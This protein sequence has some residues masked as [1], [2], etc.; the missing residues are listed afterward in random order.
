MSKRTLPE[1]QHDG[2]HQ[3]DTACPPNLKRQRLQP[4]SGAPVADA[5]YAPYRK[6]KLPNSF[7]VVLPGGPNDIKSVRLSNLQGAIPSSYQ[8]SSSCPPLPDE[9]PSASLDGDHQFTA[10]A[11][12]PMESSEALVLRPSSTLLPSLDQ[13]LAPPFHQLPPADPL[14]LSIVPYRQHFDWWLDSL[15]ASEAEKEWLLANRHLVTKLLEEMLTSSRSAGI[16]EFPYTDIVAL[17]NIW[18]ERRE[19]AEVKR[20]E[21]E[22]SNGEGRIF[23]VVDEEEG[24]C[25]E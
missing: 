25:L 18:R 2:H 24:M 3:Q 1:D 11:F 19:E 9:A 22:A 5:S 15:R 20:R 10:D 23:E 16:P 14:S 12:G 7:D 4:T 6:R 21:E 17:R 8:Q 13:F